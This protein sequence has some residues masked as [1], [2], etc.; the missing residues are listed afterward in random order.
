M[1]KDTRFTFEFLSAY[2]GRADYRLYIN[3]RANTRITVNRDRSLSYGDGSPVL[4][5]E[6]DAFN[7]MMATRWNEARAKYPE[8][9][10][11]EP[12][13]VYHTKKES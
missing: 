11:S 4:K 9:Y 1:A 3:G 12:N 10:A 6:L 5:S 8:Y 2:N 13:P 7:A